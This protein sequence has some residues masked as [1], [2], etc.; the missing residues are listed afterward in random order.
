MNKTKHYLRETYSTIL[1]FVNNLSTL[2]MKANLHMRHNSVKPTERPTLLPQFKFTLIGN[3]KFS[4]AFLLEKNEAD[5]FDDHH[6]LKVTS[7][8]T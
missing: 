8:I 3:E 7:S 2:L 6:P 5:N 4:M 1:S